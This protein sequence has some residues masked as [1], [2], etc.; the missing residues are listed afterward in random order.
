MDKFQ[1]HNAV[2]KP[3]WHTADTHGVTSLTFA[4]MHM[5]GIFFA[6]RIANMQTRPLYSFEKRKVYQEHGYK[7]VPDK[8]INED[9]IQDEW[10]DI[11]RF[12]AT[13]TL[14]VTPASQ[15]FQRLNSN[16]HKHP[17]YRALKEFGHIIETI[18][19]LRYIDEPDIRQA[20]E[21]ELNKM[22]HIQRFSKA[23]FHDNNHIFQQ[24]TREEQLVADG[25]KRLIE[26]AIIGY[27]YLLLSQKVTNTPEGTARNALLLQIKRSSMAAWQHIHM[28]GEYDF[29]DERV[30]T[31]TKFP[32]SK[33]MGLKAT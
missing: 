17:L 32:L 15:L 18:Y 13:I 23:V 5:L 28:D 26:N 25:L 10:D 21:R 33:I 9:L 31:I 6:P 12:M 7:L 2:V 22:E 19:I 16:A 8:L 24:A 11:L 14:R 3:D 27:N 4:A 1:M 29:S 30:N 20:V